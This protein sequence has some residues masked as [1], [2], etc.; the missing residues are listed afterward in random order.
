M[1]QFIGILTND[2]CSHPN[3]QIQRLSY[4]TTQYKKKSNTEPVFVKNE[5]VNRFNILS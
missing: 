4:L 5:P 1:L 2:N 3:S